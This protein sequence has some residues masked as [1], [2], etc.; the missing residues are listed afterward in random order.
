MHHVNLQSL[1]YFIGK[2]KSEVSGHASFFAAP[3]SLLAKVRGE[4]RGQF[5]VRSKP[6]FTGDKL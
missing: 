1:Q 3:F 5:G 2:A 4:V 6:R